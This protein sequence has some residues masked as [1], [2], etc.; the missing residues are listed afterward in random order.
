LHTLFKAVNRGNQ[1]TTNNQLGN[2]AAK[3]CNLQLLPAKSTMTMYLKPKLDA[4]APKAAPK[5]R[6]G[7]KKKNRKNRGSKITGKK[8]RQN[9]YNFSQGKNTCKASKRTCDEDDEDNDNT[10]LR[11]I[12][13]CATLHHIAP[14]TPTHTNTL[15][16]GDTGE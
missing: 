2:Q 6:R 8:I 12:N 10:Q 13:H 15:L 7:I 11:C 16:C 9:F 3:K 1:P 4:T 5:G 14:S